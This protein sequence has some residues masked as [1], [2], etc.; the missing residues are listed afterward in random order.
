MPKTILLDSTLVHHEGNVW[1]VFTNNKLDWIIV[2]ITVKV[3]PLKQS[4]QKWLE[5]RH[6][7]MYHFVR[8]A[9]LV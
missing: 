9:G 8:Q 4:H 5:S 6:S 7:Q 3:I 1:R 2:G